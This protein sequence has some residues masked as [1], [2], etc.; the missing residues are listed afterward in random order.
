VKNQDLWKRL[1]APLEDGTRD[2]SF[3]RVIGHADEANNILVDRL[4]KAA[5][6]AC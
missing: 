5:A 1:F 4:A 3:V 6:L 2:V